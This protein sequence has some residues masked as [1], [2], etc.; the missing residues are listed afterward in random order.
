SCTYSASDY[1]ACA[2]TIEAGLY[3]FFFQAEDGI[4]DRNVTGVQT[5]ALPISCCFIEELCFSCIELSALSSVF[6]LLLLLLL[7][8]VIPLSSALLP[9]FPAG[10]VVLSL[11]GLSSPPVLG[12]SEPLLLESLAGV[13]ISG[14]PSPSLSVV[15]VPFGSDSSLFGISSLSASSSPSGVPFPSESGLV[16]SVPAASSSL[17]FTPSPSISG[18]WLSGVPS[19]SVSL[20]CSEPLLL[21]SLAGVVTSGLPSPSLSVGVVPFG[22]DSSLFGIPSLSVSS[23]PSDVPF[24]SESGFVGSVPM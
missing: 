15:V 20:G 11:P 22:S 12:L 19:P 9:S 10:L 7:L 18:S 3:S 14:L 13:V 17:L 23:S 21:E 1:P 16:G 2:P 8:L 4:R 24:P 6:T 5:C